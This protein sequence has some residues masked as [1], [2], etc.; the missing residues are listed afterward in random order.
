LQGIL[1]SG[2]EENMQEKI[3]RDKQKESA[4]QDFSKN[5]ATLILDLPNVLKFEFNA[6]QKRLT[7]FLKEIPEC[8]KIAVY[9]EKFSSVPE[10]LKH[11][12]R[13]WGYYT[14]PAVSN[15]DLA[16]VEEAAKAKI[17]GKR[18]FVVTCDTA[19]IRT[20]I[21]CFYEKLHLLHVIMLYSPQPRVSSLLLEELREYGVKHEYFKDVPLIEESIIQKALGWSLESARQF[22]EEVI[23][24][25][26]K[27]I[28]AR[29]LLNRLK[30]S[31]GDKTKLKVEVLI[32][33]LERNGIM[34]PEK[35]IARG[36]WEHILYFSPGDKTLSLNQ[37]IFGE[38]VS[39]V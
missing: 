21:Y 38:G 28:T 4:F 22:L 30:E 29:P 1:F 19:I 8:L 18:V 34:E 23:E 9:H 11:L 36:I 17:Q 35:I 20:L 5:T 33:N 25:G 16:V 12:L 7:G 37:E 6:F 24:R 13:K 31:F 15:V 27:L 2:G 14:L 10:K 3:Q 39:K 32:E 26:M